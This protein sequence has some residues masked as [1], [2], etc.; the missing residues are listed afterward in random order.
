MSVNIPGVIAMVFFYLLVLGTGIWGSFKARRK[1]R[2][3]AASAVEMALLGNRGIKWLL[4]IFT[5]TATWVG[6]GLICGTVEMMYTPSLGLIWTVLMFAGYT[7]TFLIGGFLLAKP[8]R[9][10]RCVTL[11]DPFQAKYG[12]VVTVGM[13]LTSL[14]NEMICL[15]TTLIALGGTMSV[16]L[17]LPYVGCIWISAAVAIVYTLL[18]GLYSVAYTDVIQIVLMF[19]SLWLCVPFV[20]MNP[21]TSDIGK[22]VMNNTLHPSWIG[23]L[24][25]K[26]IWLFIDNFLFFTLGGLGY[27]CFHQRILSASSLTTAKIT[28]T[29]AAVLIL[30]FAIPVV[31]IGAAAA[32]TDWNQTSYGTPSPYERGEAAMVLPIVLQHL[33]PSFIAIIGIGCV[34]AAVMSSADSFLLSASSIFVK[35]IYK[36]LLRPQA[37]DNEIQ[38]VIRASVVVVGLIGTSLATLENSIL[39]FWFLGGEVTYIVIFPQLMSALFFNA[40]NEYG[41]IMGFLVGIVI[42]LLS[43]DPSLGIPTVIHFPGC[44]LEDGVYFQYAPVRTISMLCAL[45]SIL[46]F[47]CLASVLFSR[48]LLPKKWDVFQVTGRNS[49]LSMKSSAHKTMED[50]PE[51]QPDTLE[52]VLSTR[53]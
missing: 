11:M 8:M 44:T 45:A 34:A 2:K 10:K 23:T 25:P 29:A 26:R 15:P 40:A 5:M 22:T 17:D 28:C 35:N 50:K 46:L 36:N 39:L 51:S 33:T 18:G 49:Q 41:A 14:M 30:I 43:G 19:F 38:W 20:L 4:G 6:G 42:R 31:L 16:V 27:Q 9:E 7:V 48:R 3:S 52:P 47:S 21:H 12:R 53:F 13:S 37:S 1:Q 24:E 32:S